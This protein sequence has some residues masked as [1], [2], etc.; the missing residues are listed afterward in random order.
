MG[1]VGKSI[2]LHG[3]RRSSL[4]DNTSG[5]VLAGERLMLHVET[6]KNE[7]G[8][9]SS[10]GRSDLELHTLYNGDGQV[11]AADWLSINTMQLF[12]G[13]LQSRGDL[14]L[15]ISDDPQRFLM[16]PAVRGELR[17]YSKISAERDLTVNAVSLTNRH[18]GNLTARGTAK[19]N[20]KK[21]LVNYGT[22]SGG[23]TR[24]EASEIS[25]S[26]Q[27]SAETGSIEIKAKATEHFGLGGE[28][29]ANQDIYI[30]ASGDLY[31][32]GLVQ[33]GNDL[34]LSAGTKIINIG[35]LLAQSDQGSIRLQAPVINIPGSVMAGQDVT[36]IADQL[37]LTGATLSTPGTL[38][39]QTVGD[40]HTHQANFQAT[41]LDIQARNLYNASGSLA[42]KGDLS[43]T[44]SGF[45]DN[46]GGTL[47][48]GGDLTLTVKGDVNQAGALSSWRDMKVVVAGKLENA[49]VVSSGGDLL[50]KATG[51]T[52]V[53][54]GELTARGVHTLQVDEV[55]TN[56]GLIDGDATHIDPI[57]V[58][59][60]G[61]LYGNTLTIRAGELINEA[62]PAGAAIL[63]SHGDMDL[64]VARLINRDHSLIYAGGDLRVGSELDATVRASRFGDKPLSDYRSCGSS[65]YRGPLD[66]K[67]ECRLHQHR[68][69]HFGHPQNLLPP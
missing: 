11:S 50:V 40:I 24:I 43:A 26:G 39:L 64:G 8:V 61:R 32:S 27:I 19:L 55:L 38:A 6:L 49:G 13:T 53:A 36:L 28:L 17:N 4:L 3:S 20:I 1:L 46:T 7:R 34:S 57:Q 51:L 14:L 22:I 23:H 54:S 41:N 33:A 58:N 5:S 69:D 21:S 60:R 63:A 16:E 52:N 65:G 10:S 35:R 31:M 59:N 48:A 18:D 67:R 44:L 66:P 30:S 45:L 25:N 15:T 47:S 2:T 12:N 9:L 29:R 68:G 62:G 42:T 37:E 56:L